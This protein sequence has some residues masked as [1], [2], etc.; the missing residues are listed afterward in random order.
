M[1]ISL[2]PDRQRNILYAGLGAVTVS[3]ALY[4]LAQFNLVDLG[5][6][7]VPV[8]AA[9]FGRAVRDVLRL[10]RVEAV[11][12]VDSGRLDVTT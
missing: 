4:S 3:A 10:E 5:A 9:F 1:A 12:P 7:S 8:L 2:M 6:F 11:L